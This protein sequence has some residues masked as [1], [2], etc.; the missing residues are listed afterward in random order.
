MSPPPSAPPVY[1]TP[2]TRTSNPP[3]PLRRVMFFIPLPS[4]KRRRAT[5]TLELHLACGHVAYTTAA[6]FR[7][8]PP[9][10]VHCLECR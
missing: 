10:R 1:T 3:A 7:H 2:T 6:A 4:R 9:W 8:R 5:R